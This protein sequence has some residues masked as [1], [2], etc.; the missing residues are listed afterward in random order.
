MSIRQK[1]LPDF[2]LKQNI[3]ISV[4]QN[5]LKEGEDKKKPYIEYIIQISTDER[6]WK[7]KKQYRQFT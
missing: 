4:S 7:I 5:V 3:H 1:T 2:N 6:K